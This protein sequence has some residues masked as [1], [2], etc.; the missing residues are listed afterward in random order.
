MK[1]LFAPEIREVKAIAWLPVSIKLFS[2]GVKK[3]E[4][5]NFMT[6]GD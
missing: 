1:N 5:S 4:S 2:M 3:Y 6:F